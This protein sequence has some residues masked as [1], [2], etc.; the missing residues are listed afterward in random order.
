MNIDPGAPQCAAEHQEI[1]DNRNR[2]V[3]HYA[4]GAIRAVARSSISAA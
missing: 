2:S 4:R 3:W 1:G